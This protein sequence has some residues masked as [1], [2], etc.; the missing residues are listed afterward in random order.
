MTAMA[1]DTLK[2][3]RALR[4]AGF[5]GRQAE[6]L[7]ATFGD[8]IGE[9]VASKTDIADVKTSIAELRADIYRHLWLMAVGIVGVTV[10]LVKVIP[11]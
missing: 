2:A 11:G 7:V 4:D 6:V 9:Q 10:T 1:F 5:E 8:T 3:A